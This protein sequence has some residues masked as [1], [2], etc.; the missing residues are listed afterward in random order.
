VRQEVADHV[1]HVD[2]GLLVGH[3]DVHVHAEDQKGPRELLEFLDDILIALAGGDDLIDPAGKRM[4]AGG[5]DL[6][7]GALGGGD[8]FT[9][10]AMHFDAQIADVIADA[11]TGLDDGLMHLALDLLENVGGS[12]GD[13]LHDVRAQFAR[14]RIDDLEFFLYADGE[15]VSHEV[16]FRGWPWVEQG[17]GSD[18]IRFYCGKFTRGGETEAAPVRRSY[19]LTLRFFGHPGRMSSR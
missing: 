6:Q 18:I 14:F 2:R 13:Q 11:R 9:A 7:P 12:G 17:T 19:S 8:K 10:S 3:G 1:H 5:G 15:A 4:R 16:A